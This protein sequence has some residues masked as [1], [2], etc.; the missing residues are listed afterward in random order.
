MACL[1]VE[2]YSFAFLGLKVLFHTKANIKL[3]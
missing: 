2:R 1:K 3:C